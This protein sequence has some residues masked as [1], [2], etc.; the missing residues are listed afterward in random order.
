[1]T[2]SNPND[3]SSSVDEQR[4]EWEEFQFTVCETGHVNVCNKSHNNDANHTY[5]VEV[6][7]GEAVGCSCPHHVHRDAHCKHQVAVEQS[8]IVLSSA[9]AAASK[10]L[11]TDGGERQ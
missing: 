6:N 2:R 11:L 10:T 9:N 1:M 5:S 3:E 7:D 8:P 4:A